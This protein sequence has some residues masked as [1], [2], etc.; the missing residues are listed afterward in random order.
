MNKKTYFLIL[1]LA[2]FSFTKI[3]SQDT[4]K[5]LGKI[6]GNIDVSATGGAVYT[7]PIAVP[8]GTKGMQPNITLIYNSQAGTGVMGKGW[9]ISGLSA[10]SRGGKTFYHDNKNE[11]V[12]FDDTDHFISDGMTL[13]PVN[14]S[15]GAEGTEYRTEIESYVRFYSRGRIGNSPERFE[16]QMKNGS[17]AEYGSNP[18]SRYNTLERNNNA[19]EIKEEPLSWNISKITD[20]FGNYMTFTYINNSTTGDFLISEIKYTGNVAANQAPYNKVVFEYEDYANFVPYYFEGVQ[21][22]KTKRLKRIKTSVENDQ[23]VKTYEILYGTNT[24]N[25][26][27]SVSEIKEI[28]YLGEELNSTKFNWDLSDNTEITYQSVNDIYGVNYNL[29]SP[30][31]RDP[32]SNERPDN[33]FRIGD[34]DGDG[35]KDIVVVGRTSIYDYNS[36]FVYKNNGDGTF[37]PKENLYTYASNQSEN[38]KQILLIDWDRD[39][40]DDLITVHDFSV[41]I[42]KYSSSTNSFEAETVIVDENMFFTDGLGFGNYF[43]DLNGDGI[44]DLIK[45]ENELVRYRYGSQDGAFQYVSYAYTKAFNLPRTSG[46]RVLFGDVNGDG[47]SDMVVFHDSKVYV[48][49]SNCNGFDDPVVWSSMYPLNNLYLD[50]Q[51]I[52]I[53]G[54]GMADIAGGRQYCYGIDSCA[55]Y[56]YYVSLSTG[57]NFVFSPEYSLFID[58]PNFSRLNYM[59]YYVDLNNDG[60][61]DVIPFE[62]ETYIY[63]NTGKSF[64]KTYTLNNTMG[65]NESRLYPRFIYDFNGDNIPDILRIMYTGNSIISFGEKDDN[66]VVDTIVDGFNNSIVVDY[67]IYKQSYYEQAPSYPFSTI[68]GILKVKSLKNYSYSHDTVINLNYLFNYPVI[69]LRGKG[70]LGFKE[71]QITDNINKTN[72]T[73]RFDLVESIASLLSSKEIFKYNNEPDKTIVTEFYYGDITNLSIPPSKRFK[74]N[75]IQERIVDDFKHNF[76]KTDWTYDVYGN[77]TKIDKKIFPY[78]TGNY[79]PNIFVNTMNLIQYSNINSVWNFKPIYNGAIVTDENNKSFANITYYEYSNNRLTKEKHHFLNDTLRR[80]LQYNNYNAF[81]YPLQVVDSTKNKRRVSDY[82]Y[83]S[84]GRW[85]TQSRDPFGII[86]LYERDSKYGNLIKKTDQGN[87]ITNYTYDAW[88]RLLTTTTPEGEV[89]TNSYIWGYNGYA[90]PQNSLYSKI[91]QSNI[92]GKVSVTYDAL[93]REIQTKDEA[94]QILSIVETRYNQKGLVAKK[95][96]PYK[97]EGMSES[98]KQWIEYTYDNENRIIGE[99]SPLLLNN[100]YQYQSGIF[101]NTVINTNNISN[102]TITQEYNYLGQL[103]KSTDN[104]GDI[105]YTYTAAG[106]PD[107][108]TSLNGKTII[109]YDE[110]GNRRSITEPNSGTQYTYYNGYGDITKNVDEKGTITTYTYASTGRLANILTTGADGNFEHIFITYETLNN[111]SKGQLKTRINR[112][113]NI[114]STAITTAYQYD[115]LGRPNKITETIDGKNFEKEFTYNNKGQIATVKYPSYDGNNRLELQNI[116]NSQGQLRTIKK[117]DKDLWRRE[118]DNEY[119]QPLRVILG[120]S[121]GTMYY[122]NENNQLKKINSGTLSDTPVAPVDPGPR[123]LDATINGLTPGDLPSQSVGENIQKWV[124]EYNVKG[125]MSSRQDSLLMQKENFT[126]DNLDRLTNVNQ[127]IIIP[128]RLYNVNSSISYDNQGNIQNKTD[129]GAYT[130][131]NTKPNAISSITEPAPSLP[132]LFKPLTHNLNTETQDI[133]YNLHNKIEK[134]TQ[135]NKELKFYYNS[136]QARIKAEYKEN[137]IIQKTTYYIGNY[138]CEVYPNGRIRELSYI[139]TNTGHTIINLKDNNNNTPTDSLYYIFKD[140]LGSYDRITNQLGQ[141]VETYS[142]DAWGNRR[143]P[144]NWRGAPTATQIENYKF[145]R[146]FTGHE[147]MDKFQLI[148]MNGRLY[149]PV[150]ARFLSP[151][152]YVAN[153]TFT[154]DFNRY[155]YCRNNPL[156]YTDPSGEFIWI[157]IIAGAVMGGFTNWAF[158]GTGF[159]LEGL[160]YFGVGAVA[161][162]VGGLAGGAVAGVVGT[163]FFAG[164]LTGAAGGAAGGFIGAAGNAW[165]G[166]ADLGNGLEKGC[167]GASLGAVT[168][169]IMGGISGGINSVKH[170]GNFWTGKGITYDLLATNASSDKIEIGEGMEYTNEY[171]KTFSDDN[172]GKDLKGVNNLY[173]DGTLPQG[174]S[175]K[176]DAVINAKGYEVL[177]CTKYLGFGKGSDVYLFRASFVS[178]E[179][180]FFTMGHEYMHAAFFDASLLNVKKQHASIHKWEGFQSKIWKYNESFYAKRYYLSQPDYDSAYDYNKFGFF[181]LNI[182]P[183]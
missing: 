139:N 170:G 142:F 27:F 4:S 135:G 122:Y 72:I 84:K 159:T 21:Y 138:E 3:F 133:Q 171:A 165:I 125:L 176:G 15:N 162:A 61:V 132:S 116:Y 77:I 109:T 80:E 143:N 53:N 182:K 155:S 90:P 56:E 118:I 8:P 33:W 92:N 108:I 18:N 94:K 156:H 49:L 41:R 172:F 154:Q 88:G 23:L 2:I 73:K 34:I 150:I 128:P 64:F 149:D 76:S 167:S 147:H 10:I 85:L 126:Y 63:L 37:R 70:F 98:S 144:N 14:G 169:G 30:G 9:N 97:L 163:G 131:D 113:N 96:L 55:K 75:K 65:G 137:N 1:S 6:E 140:H 20:E 79:N 104:G 114:L 68:A 82:L 48:Y 81:G 99:V 62:T 145:T 105:T 78:T 103:E 127:Q 100:T 151:D 36:I 130:Y 45:V 12:K 175:T 69:H 39:G 74:V 40:K 51:L 180:L 54:D 44:L 87:L 47:M 35:D 119:G 46:H 19:L 152:P 31:P 183:W 59:W 110:A 7:I 120:N 11:K 168:G 5:S 107:T 13:I 52:D 160:K 38:I 93:G 111:A 42:S 57:K 174:Y 117:G 67:D 60:L 16:A 166:G 28:N 71:M 124:Y 179:Q 123:T 83:D 43:T 106:Q 112:L 95:S 157:P 66:I 58:N 178:K 177:G 146:G 173:A 141:I 17:I 115:N 32:E 86:T 161:G 121:T 148:N 22:R 158:S 26:L 91:T 136:S 181:I 29:F 129:I 102:T 89:I 101:T 24:S 153:N 134:I 164:A 50:V 25:T